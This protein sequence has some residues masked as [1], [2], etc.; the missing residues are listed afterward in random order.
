VS[1]L[2]DEL[3]LTGA[4][5]YAGAV[6]FGDVYRFQVAAASVPRFGERQIT[7]SILA[8]DTTNSEFLSS[9]LSPAELE[10]RFER[11]QAGEPYRLAMISGFVDEHNQ[12]WKIKHMRET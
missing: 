10:I 8:G 1:E 6:G 12:A 4:A 2:A 7:L 3:V 9:H 5:S 11:G